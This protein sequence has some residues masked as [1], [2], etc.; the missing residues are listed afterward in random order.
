MDVQLL[1]WIA[2]ISAVLSLIFAYMFYVEIFSSESGGERSREI[3]GWLSEG[4]GSFLSE[5]FRIT[6]LFFVS[7]FVVL[8][9]MSFLKLLSPWTPVAFLVSGILSS[10]GL[11]ASTRTSIMTVE[12][13]ATAAGKSL[14]Q[15]LNITLKGGAVSGFVTSGFALLEISGWWLFL[16]WVLSKKDDLFKNSL[17]AIK[18]ISELSAILLTFALGACCHALISRIVGG[19]FKSASGSAFEQAAGSDSQLLSDDPKNPSVV[20]RNVGR[21]AEGI[22][23]S[24]LDFYSSNLISILTAASLGA[25]AFSGFELKVQISAIVLPIILSA[26]GIIFSL[27]GIYLIS[28]NEEANAKELLGSLARGIYIAAILFTIASLIVVLFMNH[29]KIFAAILAGL[30]AGLFIIWSTEYYTSTDFESAK[31]ITQQFGSGVP[32]IIVEGY[33]AGMSSV[34]FPLATIA[35]AFFAAFM[36]AGGFEDA[37]M[38]FYGVALAACSMLSISAVSNSLKAFSPI[39]EAAFLLGKSVHV[40][41]EVKK[42]LETLDMLGKFTLNHIKGYLSGAAAFSSLALL[43]S[44]SEEIRHSLARIADPGKLQSLD[45]YFFLEGKLIPIAQAKIQQFM[46][47]YDVNIANPHLILG[48]IFGVMLVYIFSSMNLKIVSRAAGILIDE[49]KR[50]YKEIAPLS[51]GEPGA[52]GD[53][54]ACV[55]LLTKNINREATTS[56]LTATLIPVFVGLFFGIPGI[57]GL[58][59]GLIIAGVSMSIMSVTM[60]GVIDNSKKA[61]DFGQ[62]SEKGSD[63]QKNASAAFIALDQIRD[64]S[65]SLLNPLLKFVCIVAIISSGMTVAFSPSIQ[66][67]FG[68]NPLELRLREKAERLIAEEQ[69]AFPD[70]NKPQKNTEEGYFDDEEDPLMTSDDAILPEDEEGLWGEGIASEAT[71]GIAS[72]EAA[73]ASGSKTEAPLTPESTSTG[74]ELKTTPK[75][76]TSGTSNTKTVE[77]SG[78]DS[79][80]DKA[81]KSETAAKTTSSTDTGAK[82]APKTGETGGFDSFDDKA[83]KS[84]TGIKASPSTDAGSKAGTK[85]S[86]TGGFDSFEEKPNS[87]PPA[88][89]VAPPVQNTGK[90]NPT[91]SSLTPAAPTTQDSGKATTTSSSAAP[92]APATQSASKLPPSSTQTPTSTPKTETVAPATVQVQTTTTNP[93]KP[94]PAEPEK[95]SKDSPPSAQAIQTPEASKQP[96]PTAAPQPASSDSAAKNASGTAKKGA[97]GFEDF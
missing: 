76:G 15:C 22:S 93:V 95:L 84:D 3:N 42:R 82:S 80:D 34:G 85:T 96:A 46:A 13:A 28:G 86:E 38:G 24:S 9:I 30:F 72:G 64:S 35:V 39:S 18:D 62:Q 31:N 44:Y 59:A 89:K 14:T 92:A 57:T 47:Y 53:Y 51:K 26:F 79:F 29:F 36:A 67:A 19:I 20:T 23:G 68:L 7:I 94:P 6:A 2:P 43:F 97:G 78:F 16:N 74:S 66:S 10:I 77:T 83:S 25:A 4:I 32:G 50:Q 45:Y 73:L 58:M 33:T 55:A 11:Y 56:L 37:I 48:I 75:T 49:V 27:L 91:S 70:K 17:F 40:V 65:G 88:Q 8:V 81:G 41:P 69:L 21:I 60:G 54:I 61:Q 63:S 87:N 5:Q 52:K 1:F 12:K 90:T 71:E